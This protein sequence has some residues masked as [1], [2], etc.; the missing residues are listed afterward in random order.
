MRPT[1]F[2]L[3]KARGLRGSI[4]NDGAG[5]EL[6]LQASAEQIDELL[7]A[8]ENE[9]PTL[10]RIDHCQREPID[11]G[12]VA[13]GG[14]S[15]LPS[16]HGDPTAQVL[17][18]AATCPACLAES[19]DPKQRRYRYPFT[20]CTHCGPRFSIQQQ[21]P[22]DRA[23]TTM[24]EF[25][26]CPACQHEYQDVADRRYH[27]Q[28]IACPQCGPQCRYVDAKGQVLAAADDALEAAVQALLVGEVIAIKGLSG[29]HL[30]CDARSEKSISRLRLS[31][32]RPSKPLALMGRDL[33][34]LAGVVEMDDQAE[35]AL[36]SANAPIVILP[37]CVSCALPAL[38][39]PGLQQLGVMLPATPLQHL[40]LA[41]LDFPLVMTSGNP[42]GAPP[43]TGNDH[44]L[45]ALGTMVSGFL[46]HDRVIANRLDDS[47]LQIHQ[48]RSQVLRFARGLAPGAFAHNWPKPPKVLALGAQLKSSFALLRERE[49]IVSQ[50]LGDL[51]Q[52]ANL[53]DLEASV[54]R[55]LALYA[56]KPDCVAVD[57]H[58]GYLSHQLGQRLAQELS[59]P[60]LE[61]Q[62]HHAHAAVCLAEQGYP[63]DGPDTL[64]V[65]FDGLGYGI[66]GELWGGEFLRVNF[67]DFERLACWRP[68]A[69]PGATA[70]I[71]ESWRNLF[72]II[73]QLGGWAEFSTTYPDVAQTMNW[74]KS[75][76]QM[77]MLLDRQFN[78]PACSSVGRSFDAMAWLLG[79]APDQ[80]S[81]EGEAAMRLQAAAEQA[82]PAE[83]SPIALDQSEALWQLDWRPF[84]SSIFAARQAQL[85]VAPLAAAFHKVL[86]DAVVSTCV[87]LLEHHPLPPSVVLSGGVFQN[88]PLRIRCEQ[89]LLEHGITVLSP[90]QLPCNDGGIATGQAFIAAATMQSA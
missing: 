21:I 87:A 25:S 62:H 15:I 42:S 39:A 1:L 56:F 53:D 44:A 9:L 74:P 55:Y 34:V 4:R 79:V 10:A 83:L 64:A 85:P 78:A 47:V 5:V 13:D 57:A 52:A 76:E 90:S 12:A 45:K 71:S 14:L 46:L 86:A 75:P 72:A 54:D 38:L 51:E 40:L 60:L 18:D 24:A 22:W 59:V 16:V 58:P 80:I 65:C 20:N 61:V 43:C 41:S 82:A 88:L 73:H 33:T 49:W 11:D 19:V 17:P 36:L 68:A 89:G 37:R 31:K 3:A 63:S 27:A 70:A 29:F 30:A 32:H 35:Q 69:L 7:S 66:N 6:L 8:L 81:Y 48:G 77:Q 26:L 23:G 50:H 28:P 84:W 2:R 67:R